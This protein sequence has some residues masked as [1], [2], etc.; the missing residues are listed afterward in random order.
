MTGGLLQEPIPLSILKQ[1]LPSVIGADQDESGPKAPAEDAQQQKHPAAN[2]NA[3][4]IS[5][6]T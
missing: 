6:D 2:G 1:S 3:G 5:G 4:R